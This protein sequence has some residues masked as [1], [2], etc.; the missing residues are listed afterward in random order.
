MY[1]LTILPSSWTWTVMAWVIIATLIVTANAGLLAQT[2]DG[3]T[4]AQETVCDD[5]GF[6]GAAWGL[7]NAY[8]EAMDCDHETPQASARACEQVLANFHRLTNGEDPPCE[9]LGFMDLVDFRGTNPCVGGDKDRVVWVEDPDGTG[10]GTQGTALSFYVIENPTSTP[11]EVVDIVFSDPQ[12]FSS[13]TLPFTVPAFGDFALLLGFRPDK[14]GVSTGFADIFGSAGAIGFLEL[15]GE[16][17]PDEV[18]ELVSCAFNPAPA[19]FGEIVTLTLEVSDSATLANIATL[20][21]LLG[22]I[23]GLIAAFTAVAEANPADKADML[24]ASIST[25]MNTTAFG[26]MAAIPLLLIHALLQTKTNALVD[27]LEMASVK[28]LNAVTE[29]QLK[30]TGA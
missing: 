29:R 26:L 11:L 20:L 10:A 9:S 22:T 7:C 13:V 16:G 30:S 19:I 14:V 21:G 1:S 28:F 25:A 17:F 4:P 5:A 23:I 27:S 8:C 12:F 24:S 18:P 2:A 15:I 6:T 3:E